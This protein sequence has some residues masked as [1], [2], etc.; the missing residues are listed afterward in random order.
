M[1]DIHPFVMKI[2]NERLVKY[3]AHMTY[4]DRGVMFKSAVCKSLQLIL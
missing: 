1:I 4:A 2:I 3:F